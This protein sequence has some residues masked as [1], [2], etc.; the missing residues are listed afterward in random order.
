MM[1]QTLKSISSQVDHIVVYLNRYDHVPDFLR[2][3]KISI[4]GIDGPDLGDVGK[5]YAIEHCN[6]EFFLTIDDDIIYPHNYVAALIESYQNWDADT[7]ICVHGNKIPKKITA[8]YYQEKVGLHFSSILDKDTLV[9]VPGTGTM[10]IQPKMHRISLDLFSR[11][12][13]SDIWL[14]KYAR[15]NKKRVVAIKRQSLW[16]KEQ[17]HQVWSDSIYSQHKSNDGF[18]INIINRY[19]DYL[20]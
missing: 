13:M 19:L 12:N 8:S 2:S 7:I 16:L 17:E 1:R 10:I 18:Q 11:P 6:A 14:Y 5:F 4:F 15:L 20:G 3:D 9:D